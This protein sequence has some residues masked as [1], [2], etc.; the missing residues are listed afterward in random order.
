[1]FKESLRNTAIEAINEDQLA[2]GLVLFSHYRRLVGNVKNLAVEDLSVAEEL[3]VI[4]S[5]PFG[6]NLQYVIVNNSSS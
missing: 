4:K 5:E 6:N 2:S 3:K 1:M